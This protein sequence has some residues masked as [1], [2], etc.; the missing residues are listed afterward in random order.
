M[1]LRQKILSGFILCTMALVATA[2]FA[3]RNNEK[4]ID[5]TQWVTHTHE[6]LQ[7][8]DEILT[9][10][11]DAETGVRGYVVTGNEVFLEP[12]NNA[13]SAIDQHLDKVRGL[14]VDNPAEEKN[15]DV[16]QKQIG[17]SQNYLEQAIA[18]RKKGFEG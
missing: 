15:I 7:E 12:Y 13:W 5:T 9:L 18:L 2:I 14:T 6:V 11:V 3:I 16:L 10:T 8:F 4:F 17:L 1:K